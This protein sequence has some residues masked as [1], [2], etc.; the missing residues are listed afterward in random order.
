MNDSPFCDQGTK[1]P[2]DSNKSS[3]Q[4]MPERVQEGINIIKHTLSPHDQD[5]LSDDRNEYI[6][7]KID[8]ILMEKYSAGRPWKPSSLIFNYDGNVR[9]AVFISLIICL[10]SVH[11]PINQRIEWNVRLSSLS[12]LHIDHE[13][14]FEL[15]INPNDYEN[16][17]L[18]S[19]SRYA[20][21]Y[22]DTKV[23]RDYKA[24]RNLFMTI[25]GKP[26]SLENSTSSFN[27]R[28]IKTW[29]YYKL[30]ECIDIPLFKHIL[31]AFTC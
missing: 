10:H 29:Y 15:N 25:E 5:R 8:D 19:L 4:H 27:M 21:E 9:N 7:R 17:G 23:D 13:V 31:D 12:I 22:I 26:S 28:K 6:K 2:V 16:E 1:P 14:F 18:K 3:S 20:L 11:R 30:T 24:K